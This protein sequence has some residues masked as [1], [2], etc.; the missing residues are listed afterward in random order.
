MGVA[1]SHESRLVWSTLALRAVEHR[2][3]RAPRP[4]LPAAIGR[5]AVR[6]R[7]TSHRSGRRA[8][9]PSRLLVG[10]QRSGLPAL[11]RRRVGPPGDR[12]RAAVREAVPGGL[13]GRALVA[14]DPAQAG[15]LPARLRRLRPG[16]RRRASAPTT[17]PASWPMP[18]SCATG[19]RSPP[20]STTP[21]GCSSCVEAEGSLAAY[22]WRFEPA[23]A[24]RPARLDQVGPGHARVEPGV[25]RTVE[26]PQAARLALRRPDDRLRVHAGHGPGQRPPRGLL[27]A[28]RGGGGP[29]SARPGPLL[30]PAGSSRR[31]GDRVSPAPDPG[32]ELSLSSFSGVSAAHGDDDGRAVQGVALRRALHLLRGQAGRRPARATRSSAR[33][34]SGVAE[35]YDWLAPAPIDGAAVRSWACPL[36]RGAAGRR[37][38]WCTTPG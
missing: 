37:S 22:V 15:D 33:R 28:R 19:P 5:L 4:A 27:G 36:G 13:P 10:R 1:P 31:P 8:R 23:A 16:G 12:R 35:G 6:G 14:D 32:A 24:D 20:P 2:S 26:G 17:R 21:R 7:P 29:R 11:P 9:R 25:D 30:A 38:S 18:A 34:R 3:E